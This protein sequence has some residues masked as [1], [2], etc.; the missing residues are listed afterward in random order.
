[1][2]DGPQSYIIRA[3]SG[4]KKKKKQ[5]N[6]RNSEFLRV[7]LMKVATCIQIAYFSSITKGTDDDSLC[8]SRPFYRNTNAMC[9]VASIFKTLEPHQA[10]KGLAILI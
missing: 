5:E 6:A 3:R 8:V 10:A 7:N 1:M 9:N 4:K 2:L